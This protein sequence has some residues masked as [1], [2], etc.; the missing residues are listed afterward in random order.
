LLAPLTAWARLR[1]APSEAARLNVLPHS[2]QVNSPL[3]VAVGLF[4]DV[5]RRGR[6]ISSPSLV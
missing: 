3:L 6:A 1:W 5:V 4:A 2:G